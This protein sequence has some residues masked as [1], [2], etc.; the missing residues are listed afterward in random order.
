MSFSYATA[1]AR[2]D[3]QPEP[4]WTP[5]M[6]DVQKL[7]RINEV[8]DRAYSLGTWD[9]LLLEV[10]GMTTTGGILTLDSEY[11]LLTAL[12][13]EC[14][15]PRISIKS[16]QVK[17]APAREVTCQTGGVP[18][19]AYDLG[20]LGTGSVGVFSGAT[21][22]DQVTGD[23]YNIV[24]AN[25]IIGLEPAGDVP[26]P[27]T[28]S[29]RQYEIVGIPSY[30]DGLTFSGIAKR[31]YV[32]ATDE[33]ATVSPDCFEGLLMGVRAF[34]WYDVGDTKRAEEEFQTA[35]GI[36]EADLGQVLQDEDM[37]RVTVEV[38]YSGGSIP[39]L[40]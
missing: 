32:Y 1:I 40:Y 18:R 38:E 19:I 28:F 4:Y 3:N 21:V 39:N 7:Q 25:Q 5:G 2:V 22:Q 24:V 15:G 36:F 31:R 12:R 14:F 29:A 10:K 27:S 26:P 16:Q 35:I 8:L 30:V 11:K 6:T 9:G 13:N 37:G 33:T 34:H 17:Y 20:D 23:L